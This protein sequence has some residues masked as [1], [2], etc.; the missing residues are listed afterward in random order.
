MTSALDDAVGTVLAKVRDSGL[1]EN[2]LIFYIS[3]NGGPPVNVS[4]STHANE[5]TSARGSPSTPAKRSGAT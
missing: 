2:T 5:Y 3:D 4:C 1:E